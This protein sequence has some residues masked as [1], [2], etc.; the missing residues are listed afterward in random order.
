[1]P[2]QIPAPEGA[3]ELFAIG[4]LNWKKN[5]TFCPL[6]FGERQVRDPL[7]GVLSKILR[8]WDQISHEPKHN[9]S[10]LAMSE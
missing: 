1:M 8:S 3:S 7:L 9:N 10:P 2:G 4:S 5:Q 6:C